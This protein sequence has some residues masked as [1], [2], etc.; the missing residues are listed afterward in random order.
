[1]AASRP[2]QNF[3]AE[4]EAGINKQINMELYASYVYQSMAFYF[5]RDDVALKGFSKFFRKSSEEEREHA[6]KLMKYQNKRG[7]RIVLQA[8][9]KPDKDEWGCGL[10]AMKTALELEKAVNQALLDLHKIAES[11]CDPQ[12]MDFIEG[13]YLE[14]QV[15][16][17]K[18]LSD[19]ITNLIRVGPGQGEWHYDRKLDS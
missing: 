7:G 5:D 2:R 14:E 3:H 18:D 4:S 1:M 17:I 12:M 6:E 8:I 13:E 10:D 19:H 11:H 9:Q 15:D 16:G